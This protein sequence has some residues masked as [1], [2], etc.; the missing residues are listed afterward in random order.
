GG[1][2]RPRALAA[3]CHRRGDLTDAA[4]D[5]HELGHPPAEQDRARGGRPPARRRRAAPRPGVMARPRLLALG[6]APVALALPPGAWAAALVVKVATERV[7]A[8]GALNTSSGH[9]SLR[10]AIRAWG[11][12]SSRSTGSGSC[13]VNWATV[14]VKAVFSGR[15]CSESGSR[16]QRAT[17]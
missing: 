3:Q 6:A 17:L 2:G 8:L 4:R 13:H 11:R 5:A 16:I 10:A 9:G 1:D 7:T 14:G 12:P 15:R